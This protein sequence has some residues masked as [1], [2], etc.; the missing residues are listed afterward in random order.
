MG[1]KNRKQ[2]CAVWLVLSR[3][4]LPQRVKISTTGVAPHVNDGE[5]CVRAY[6]KWEGSCSC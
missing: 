1:K 2:Q 3:E 4:G 6:L 5:K